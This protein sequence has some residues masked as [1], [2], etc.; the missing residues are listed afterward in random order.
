MKEGKELLMQRNETRA[1]RIGDRVI[2]HGNPIL[3]QSMTNTRTADT[4][5]TIAQVKALA[6]VSLRHGSRAELAR[7]VFML[8]FALIGENTIDLYH[9]TADEVKDGVQTYNRRKTDSV[10]QDNA[11][12]KVRV[13]PE[14]EAFISRYRA[15]D[16]LHLFNFH[17]R[18]SDHKNFN[19]MVNKGLK[20]VADAV[21]ALDGERLPECLNFYYARHT[22]AT[23]ARNECGVSFDEVHESL[24]HARRGS[25]RVT[26]IYVERDFSRV[27]DANR[28]VLDLVFCGLTANQ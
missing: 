17:K 26:D 3:I 22:W 9:A 16:G 18:Y 8:S 28:K 4:K 19:N 23:I 5:A 15:S 10:R 24:N 20:D 12:M 1:V 25:D 6:T 27:W 11:L 7:D 2:G 13:E 21:N 14:A